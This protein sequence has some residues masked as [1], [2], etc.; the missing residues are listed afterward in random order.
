MKM[1][2]AQFTNLFYYA[3]RI[4]Y[5]IMKTLMEADTLMG[6]KDNPSL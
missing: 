1:K 3:Q 6:V 5:S 2:F 4:F